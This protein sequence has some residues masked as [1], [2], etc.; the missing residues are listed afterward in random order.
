M[1]GLLSHHTAK[2]ALATPPDAAPAAA[3]VGRPSASMM[4]AADLEA[5]ML[6]SA[7]QQQESSGN[8]LLSM[9]KGKTASKQE[10]PAA[11]GEHHARRGVPPGFPTL[12]GA[13]QQQHPA[14]QQLP[15]APLPGSGMPADLAAMGPYSNSQLGQTV[16]AGGMPGPYPQAPPVLQNGSS[17]DAFLLHQQQQQE[18]AQLL[19]PHVAGAAWQAGLPPHPPGAR[20]L[21]PPLP[22]HMSAIPGGPYSLPPPGHMGPGPLPG[23]PGSLGP[24]PPV[25][26]PHAP[27]PPP[28]GAVPLMGPPVPPMGVGMP[29][30]PGQ[31]NQPGLPPPHLQQQPPL[32]GP[33]APPPLPG[34]Y[35]NSWLALGNA[36]TF[37]HLSLLVG[38][39]R[40]PAAHH[41]AA[42]V[43]TMP[44][45]W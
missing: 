12:P 40:L 2:A 22:G 37:S 19:P 11:P 35:S 24:V 5:R 27:I 29:G 8:T 7:N 39:R 15:H 31:Q 6:S 21:P 20:A 23:Q 25:L 42:A 16:S 45:C 4:T 1:L 34:T 36:G 41:A 32:A 3:P 38:R 30:M 10:Q 26:P 17:L 13:L 14:S 28:P 33:M 18:G 9:L 43:G 44:C